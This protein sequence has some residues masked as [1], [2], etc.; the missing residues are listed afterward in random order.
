MVDPWIFHSFSSNWPLVD[1]FCN[2]CTHTIWRLSNYEGSRLPR[3]LWTQNRSVASSSF[4]GSAELLCHIEGKQQT[5]N[6]TGDSV[7]H[8]ISGRVHYGNRLFHNEK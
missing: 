5:F 6:P 2:H 4:H 7:H 3:Q 1:H 8:I